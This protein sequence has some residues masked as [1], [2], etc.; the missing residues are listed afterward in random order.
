MHDATERKCE[1]ESKLEKELNNLNMLKELKGKSNHLTKGMINILDSFEHRLARLEETILP[2]Y[3]ETG[4]LQKR[5]ENIEKALKALDHVIGFYSVSQEVA[6]VVQAGPAPGLEPFLA[7]MDRLQTAQRYFEKNNPQS[8]ELENITTLFNAGGDALNREFKDLLMRHSKPVPPIVLLDL[9]GADEDTPVE[10]VPS[11][12]VQLPEDVAAELVRMADWLILHNRDEYMNVYAR[13]RATVLLKSLQQLKEHQ[14]SASGGSIQGVAAANSPMVRPKFQ[15]RHD[16]PNRRG[17]KRLQV[18]EKKANKMLMRASQTIEHS[19]G[20]TLGTRRSAIH[21]ESR[22]DVVDEQE[23]EN[24]LV[25][26]VALQ[27]LMQGERALM[28]G[29]VPLQHQ[30]QVF[31]IVIREAMDMVVQDGESIAARAKRCISRHD[32]AAVLVVFPILKHLLTLRPEFERT[33]EG[34]DQNVRAKFSSILRMLHTTGAKA[35]ENFIESVRTEP[36]TQLPKDG[37]VHELTSNVLV[38]LEQLLD[39]VDT[40]GGVLGEDPAYNTSVASHGKVDRNKALVGIYIRK[41]LEQLSQT[42]VVKSEFYGDVCLRAVFLLNNNNHVLKALQRSGLLDLV[43]LSRP[44]CEEWYHSRIREHKDAYTQSSWSKVLSYIAPSEVVP[45]SVLQNGRLRD[46]DRAA[47]KERFAGFNKEMEDIAK[48]QRSYSIPDVELRESLKRDN[49]EYILP[50]YNA[51]YERYC[52]VQF[53]KNK[54]KYIKYDP[55]GVSEMIDRFF[56]VAA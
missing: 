16:T 12:P 37:T 40:I 54:E 19:T 51:F 20:L 49:K 26:V 3:N 6:Q 45:S 13:V 2:V 15:S 25:C 4:N 24:Y 21:L 39:Y 30:H 46:K 14:K 36:S 34:C 5:Q 1:I 47:I 50:K 10:E 7:A 23:M 41:V 28:A 48:V 27:R 56:D 9:I 33:M 8:V 31:E 44:N 52:N 17:S 53:T 11:A 55:A 22:E 43:K 42:L 38:F 35:L 18:F 32:F 29:I